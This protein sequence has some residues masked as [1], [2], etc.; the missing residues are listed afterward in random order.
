M[1]ALILAAGL[2]SRLKHKT[3][4]RPKAMIE[5]N[6]KPIISFQI[7]ALQFNKIK[8]IGVVLGYKSS[9]LKNYLLQNHQDIKFSF[10]LNEEYQF[11][12]SA[13]SFYQAKEY[14]KDNTYIHLNCDVIFSK[15]LLA[16]LMKSKHSNVIAISK[17]VKLTDNMEQVELDLE[18][19]I[20][21]MDNMK[22][23]E[24]VSKAYGLAKLSSKSTKY[25]IKKIESSLK[26][27]DKNKNYYGIIRQ[28]VQK[29]NY[30]GIDINNNFL[31][32][33][34]TL[35]DLTIAVRAVNK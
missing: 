10:F 29:I 4:D 16:D 13:Y 32:E 25:I 6:N 22:F 1:K 14:I 5:I 33:V 18:N 19:K 17:K 12:N 20:I 3:K 24:A 21:K 34:N 30:Y 15:E 11:S 9:L 8:E 23:T 28:A 31:L 35:D 2:G 27:N 26:Q 7:E